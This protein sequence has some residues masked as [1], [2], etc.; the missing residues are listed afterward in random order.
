MP[1]AAGKEAIAMGEGMIKAG[2]ALSYMAEK[3][4]QEADQLR[5]IDATNEAV[6]AQLALTYDKNDGFLNFK[7]KAAL[8]RPDNKPLDVEYTEKFENQLASIEEKL[9]NDRQKKLFRQASASLTRQFLGNVNQHVAAE[10]KEFQTATLNGSIDVATQKMSINWGDPNI[11]AE[12]QKL[13]KAAQSERDKNLPPDQREANLVK[14]LSPGN[15]AVIS[16]A[17]DAGNTTYAKEYLLQ[18]A[19]Y[20]TPE[21]RL[22]LARA[23]ETGDFEART[24]KLAEDIYKES[25]GD[26]TKALQIARER[27]SGKDEDR[28][29]ERLKM[30]FA[31]D[32]TISFEPR[33]QKRAEEIY[34]E[35]NGDLEKA[36]RLARETTKGKD[37]DRIVDRLKIRFGEDQARKTEDFEPRTQKLAQE[38]YADANG[39]KTK[40]LK[41]A[42][43]RASGKDQDRVVDRLKVLFAED[44]A[45]KT[46]DFEPLTQRIAQE[47]Y[48]EAKGDKTKA[49]QLARERT[50][51]KEQDRVV[52][53]LKVLVAETKEPPDAT[54]V[55][56]ES[57]RILAASK[58]DVKA[59]LALARN[60]LEGELEN[61]VIQ[62]ITQMDTERMTL[63]ER[64]QRDAKEAGFAAYMKTGSF[65]KIPASVLAAMDPTDVANLRQFAENRSYTQTLRAESAERRHNESLY[66]KAAP[67]FLRLYS[68]VD[69]LEKMS[70]NDILLLEPKLGPQHVQTLLNRREQLQN[71]EGR[72]TAKMD[73]DQFKAIATEY[74]FDA[75]KPSTKQKEVLG[76]LQSRVD[77]MLE[78]AARK[79][80]APLSKEEKAAI[81][82]DAMKQEVEIDGFFFNSKQPALT[83]TPEQE[84]KVIV[85][86]V[87]RKAIVQAL[88]EAY[89]INKSPEY[90]PTEANIRRLYLR[91]LRK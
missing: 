18:N 5:V 88:Q 61:S 14:A 38:I 86:P 66:R 71:R 63:K 42:R 32:E 26:L 4:A 45:K 81:M 2:A 49:L 48:A 31:E 15:T 24:Q 78:D 85:P 7:G 41:L 23:V 25:E 82:K 17:V 39:D 22:V 43:E 59:A 36:L 33:T 91:G 9:G 55:Q 13:I 10:Y 21:N 58:G 75:Y 80:R 51:G 74:G 8:E 54:K 62:K 19:Q 52:E 67:E 50:T 84:A 11:V 53:R 47:I 46:E 68:D 6:K 65:N 83:L 72:L 30:R 3:A 89:K 87:E 40:A 56:T 44:E 77:M 34:Q 60:E 69:K 20:I 29:V 76:L 28:T 1:I 70:P 37:Q 64:Q 73:D 16:A 57:E 12:Q 35:S 90:E 79:K 27:T